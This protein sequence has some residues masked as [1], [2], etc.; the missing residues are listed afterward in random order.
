[1]SFV[2]VS[3]SDVRVV[4]SDSAGCVS[5]L[6]LAEGTL[7]ALS[8]WKAHDFEA[9]ISAFSYWDVQLVYS[10]KNLLYVSDLMYVCICKV[11][12]NFRNCM[13]VS[14][15]G[16]DDCKLKG[17]DLRV[18]PSRPTFTSEKLVLMLASLAFIWNV[19]LG[20]VWWQFLA[21]SLKGTQ[22][23]CAAFTATHIGN[24]SWLQAGTCP[25]VYHSICGNLTL[26]PL[27]LN[28]KL[29]NSQS[30]EYKSC[31]LG[32]SSG[33][34]DEHVLLWDGRN[35][36]QPLSESTMGGG[37]WRLKWHPTHQHLLLAACMHNDFHILNCQQAL[38][39]Y[40]GEMNK[41]TLTQN[42]KYEVWRL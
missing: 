19:H 25:S 38:G 24:T 8:Q 35:M 26:W 37:V 9:W 36:Q 39:E 2:L 10:G 16:G 30:C 15:P 27:V 29:H 20:Q 3:S 11:T 21:C 28:S 7:S 34:Y 32:F 1:M 17:W 33:S 23:V 14:T 12:V 41:E 5:V 31:V 18:G 6:S 40:K 13:G 42:S 22:W 4:C